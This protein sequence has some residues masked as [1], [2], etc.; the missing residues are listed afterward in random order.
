MCCIFICFLRKLNK[1]KQ[2]KQTNKKPNKQTNN[3]TKQKK[4][5]KQSQKQ[6]Q[7]KRKQKA[8][9]DMFSFA[10]ISL[11]LRNTKWLLSM[12]IDG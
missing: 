6:S 9:L 10:L 3:E 8:S 12:Q 11:P 2:N 5:A 7:A 4:Q 1:E